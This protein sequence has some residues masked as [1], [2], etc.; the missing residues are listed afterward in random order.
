MKAYIILAVLFS[1]LIGAGLAENMKT[2]DVKAF[3]QALENDGFVVQQGELGYFDLIKIYNE[4]LI[5]SVYGN[6]P[7]TPYLAYFMPP[8]PG[9][10][11]NERGAMIAKVLGK[12]GNATVYYSLRPD[13][14]IVFVGRTPPE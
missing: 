3:K 11:V 14:A 6:N 8:A 5:P 10:K 9:Y 1:L 12:S 2:G 4:G 7:S 13:E